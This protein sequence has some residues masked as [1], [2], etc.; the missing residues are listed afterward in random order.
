[1]D[2]IP[3]ISRI[4]DLYTRP[5]QLTIDY[6]S[7]SEQ[8]SKVLFLKTDFSKFLGSFHETWDLEL[9]DEEKIIR[10]KEF[11]SIPFLFAG[12]LTL[13]EMRLLK[14]KW[15]AGDIDYIKH[16][17]FRLLNSPAVQTNILSSFKDD[18]SMSEYLP[19]VKDALLA[20]KERRYTLSIPALFPVIEGVLLKKYGSD[21]I[22][23]TC[24]RCRRPFWRTAPR[25]LTKLKSKYKGMPGSMVRRRTALISHLITRFSI[26][27]NPILHGSMVDYASEEL[28][29][30]LILTAY[31]L[32]FLDLA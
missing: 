7:F 31:S 10:R 2:I 13:Q 25:I 28:S 30:A 21:Y 26:D 20:H 1:M 4:T 32:S 12:F 9:A 29:A 27:R 22:E 14:E 16:F 8:I 5:L 11:K 23:S 6:L 18:P 19:V 15:E 24:K 3:E 17:V